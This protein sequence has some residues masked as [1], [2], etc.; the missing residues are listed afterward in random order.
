M[1]RAACSYCSSKAL[2]PCEVRTVISLRRANRREVNPALTL[3]EGS[4]GD[5]REPTK[6]VA[7]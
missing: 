7:E 6:W 3:K 5:T 2:D 1:L 4:G